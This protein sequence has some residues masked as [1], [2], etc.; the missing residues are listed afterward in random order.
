MG[1]TDPKTPTS[2]KEAAFQLFHEKWWSPR[3][4]VLHAQLS[5]LSIVSKNPPHPCY[6][7]QCN[8]NFKW[9]DSSSWSSLPFS[10][11][12]PPMESTRSAP[13]R[14]VT[15]QTSPLPWWN[16][17]VPN[18]HSYLEHWRQHTHLALQPGRSAWNNLW[19]AGCFTHEWADLVKYSILEKRRAS[20]DYLA[21][22]S[23]G[24]QQKQKAPSASLQ[25]MCLIPILK[26]CLPGLLLSARRCVYLIILFFVLHKL[27]RFIYL[28]S[29]TLQ[30]NPH[31]LERVCETHLAGSVL[32]KGRHRL[33]RQV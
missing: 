33:W 19:T 5:F 14:K 3:K 4:Q 10:D 23:A 6:Q 26:A 7:C 18:V 11:M 22:H 28:S 2:S 8:Y 31:H 29:E 15:Y 25:L 30:R 20:S 17:T 21:L 16:Y 9:M 32:F 12:F 13:A 27:Y 1:N 24:R